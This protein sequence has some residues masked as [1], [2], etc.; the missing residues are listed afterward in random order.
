MVLGEFFSVLCLM[1]PSFPNRIDASQLH[2]HTE[3]YLV[4]MYLNLSAAILENNSCVF[5]L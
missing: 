3:Y 2:S 1:D 5:T 4:M